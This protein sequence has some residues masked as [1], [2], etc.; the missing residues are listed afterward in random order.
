MLGE[1]EFV[2]RLQQLLASDGG[3]GDDNLVDLQP[4]DQTGQV[5]GAAEHRNGQRLSALVRA[6]QSDHFQ[7]R[8]V[9]RAQLLGD[10]QRFGIGA[11]DQRAAMELA[12]APAPV[13]EAAQQKAFEHDRGDAEQPGKHQPQT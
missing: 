10:G 6:D 11:E 4:C 3:G 2:V 8:R 12:V 7:T 9:G 13:D 1:A 5:R